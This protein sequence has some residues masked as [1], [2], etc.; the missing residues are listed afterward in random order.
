MHFIVCKLNLNIVDINI[1]VEFPH[2]LWLVLEFRKGKPLPKSAQNRT[3]HRKWPATCRQFI[4]T[5]RWCA[6]SSNLALSVWPQGLSY[7]MLILLVWA[8]QRELGQATDLW[9]RLYWDTKWPALPSEIW[10]S[11]PSILL[12]SEVCDLGCINHLTS[13]KLSAPEGQ[14]VFVIVSPMPGTHMTTKWTARCWGRKAVL[15][16][17]KVKVLVIWSPGDNG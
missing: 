15:H 9:E 8:S 6:D 11:N 14:G 17:C 3:S 4:S 13:L 5:P 1:H 16:T 12:S 2:G 10:G 7:G